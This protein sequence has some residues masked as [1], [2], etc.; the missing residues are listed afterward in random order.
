[1]NRTVPL[2]L[3]L[4]LSAGL[5]GCK[6]YVVRDAQVYQTEVSFTDKLVRSAADAIHSLWAGKCVC[7]GDKWVAAPESGVTDDKCAEAADVY[8]IVS[9]NRWAWHSAMSLVNAG[10][11]PAELK[12]LPEGFTPETPPEIPPLESLCSD[13]E[14][15][16]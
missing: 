12:N 2:L 14:G 15:E 10:W 6:K 8:L 5:A 7:S 13:E 3:L 9:S 16:E 4:T 1:M 11:D